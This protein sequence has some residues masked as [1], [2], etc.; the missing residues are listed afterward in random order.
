MFTFSV[1]FVAFAQDGAT[2]GVSF[3]L[4]AA[5]AIPLGNAGENFAQSD[6]IRGMVPVWL[7]VG[8]R[9]N[10]RVYLGGFFQYGIGIAP[11]GCDPPVKC[12]SISD[13]RFGLNVHYHFQPN[14]GS[15]DPWAGIGIG[16]EIIN[17]NLLVPPYLSEHL[18]AR[19]F[20]FVNAQFGAD[21]PLS[22]SLA[23]G[24]WLGLT[25]AQY[26]RQSTDGFSRSIERTALH[27]WLMLGFRGVFN[28]Q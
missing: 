19:G 4:R 23:V 7:D 21:F 12:S 17:G 13:L 27:E 2:S 11:S 9:V 14:R 15:V 22:P 1:P 18:S 24:P 28:L 3:G 26:S 6:V 8:Y 25:F 5:Y 16:Y 10:P 20:E